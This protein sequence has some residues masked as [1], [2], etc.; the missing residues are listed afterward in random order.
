M[1]IGT[2]NLLPGQRNY[3]FG[4]TLHGNIPQVTGNLPEPKRP[5][6]VHLYDSHDA[7]LDRVANR[8]NNMS[9]HIKFNLGAHT[10]IDPQEQSLRKMQQSVSMQ[11]A[12][13]EQIE[14]K[15]ER[16]KLEKQRELDQD[17]RDL[18]RMKLEKP[19]YLGLDATHKNFSRP[20]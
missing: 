13:V 20:K 12:L 5:Q 9:D 11:R 2:E 15:T 14:E 8:Q 17:M 10:D 1:G 4:S 19:V 6:N 18:Q 3:E 7:N 16:K